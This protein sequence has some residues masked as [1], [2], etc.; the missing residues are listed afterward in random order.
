LSLFKSLRENLAEN[1]IAKKVPIDIIRAGH[2]KK[3]A[4]DTGIEAR[5]NALSFQE[6]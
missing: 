3:S 4:I 1:A 6:Q 5:I 2:H